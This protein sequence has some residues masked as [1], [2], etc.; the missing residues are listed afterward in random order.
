[1]GGEEKKKE[2][3]VVILRDGGV[4]GGDRKLGVLD[5]DHCY[6][7]TLTKGGPDLDLSRTFLMAHSIFELFAEYVLSSVILQL[8]FRKEAE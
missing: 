7:L 8:Q 6:R 2:E 1:M 4:G 3:M 5:E